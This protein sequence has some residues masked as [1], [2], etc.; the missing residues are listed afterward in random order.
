MLPTRGG[1]RTSFSGQSERFYESSGALLFA[2][3]FAVVL[4]YLVLAAQFESFVHPATIMVAV[5]AI[6]RRVCRSPRAWL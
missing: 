6:T 1:Y 2:Y 4:I 5:S 3:L